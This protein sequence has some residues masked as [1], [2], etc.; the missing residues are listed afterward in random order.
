MA[1]K[2]PAFQFYP[3]DWT[4]DLEE[5][6]LEIEGA[7]IRICCKL[8]WSETR[9]KLTK[10]PLQ[11]ARILRVS[12]EKASEILKYIQNEKIGN[13]SPEN[14]NGNEFVT[15]MSRRM[16]KEEKER[17]LTRLRVK[18]HRDKEPCNDDVTPMK[19]HSSSSS[20]SSVINNCPQKAIVDLWN[21]VLFDLPRIKIWDETREGNLRARWRMDEKYQS[22]DWWR[23]FF[24]YIRTC[25]FLMG[26]VEPGPGRKKF[27]ATLPWVVIRSN[28]LKIIEGNYK[29]TP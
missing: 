26:E 11:W 28:F 19:Q 5:H 17:E 3:N 12:E 10:S 24:E 13:I 6:S 15:V 25:P 21:E 1:N 2:N 20:S 9:G 22:L 14:L 23:G 27:I 18:R 4:R 29:A 8:W 16:V 7:W